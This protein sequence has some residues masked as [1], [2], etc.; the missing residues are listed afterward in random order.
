MNWLIYVILLLAALYLFKINPVLC[1]AIVAFILLAKLWS[2]QSK[3]RPERGSTEVDA[4]LALLLTRLLDQDEAARLPPK[5]H[6]AAGDSLG[7]LFLGDS[8]RRPARGRAPPDNNLTGE[9]L[10][11]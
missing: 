4:V 3:K 11:D 10:V 6:P 7:R 2:M 5:K 1:V 8:P 9:K